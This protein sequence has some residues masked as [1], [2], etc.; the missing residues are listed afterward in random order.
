MN[1]PQHDEAMR[2]AELYDEPTRQLREDRWLFW[3]SSGLFLGVVL[4]WLLI[5]WIKH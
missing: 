2:R 4:V 1:D 3:F 5:M